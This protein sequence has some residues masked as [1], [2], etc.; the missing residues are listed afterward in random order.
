MAINFV[1]L[2]FKRFQ[3]QPCFFRGE[4]KA[5]KVECLPRVIHQADTDLEVNPGFLNPRPMFCP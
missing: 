3:G 1:S 4:N 2:F 5:Q